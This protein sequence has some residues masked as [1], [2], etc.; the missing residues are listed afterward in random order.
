MY[1]YEM[2]EKLFLDIWE[3]YECPEEVSDP[4]TIYNILNDIIVKS[5]HW[6]VLDHY[7]HINF[8]EVKKVEYDETTGIFKLFWLD[9]NSFREKRLRHEIDEFEM[10]IWQ[11][12]GYC[13]YEYIALDIYNKDP[14]Y[15]IRNISL[16]IFPL[17]KNS[18]IMLFVDKYNR[19]YSKFFKQLQR[20]KNTEEELA[21][22][23]YILFSYCE[24][25]FIS[26]KV[27][28]DILEKLKRLMG[29]TSSMLSDMPTTIDEQLEAIKKVYNFSERN[30]VPNLLSK[31]YAITVEN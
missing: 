26:P 20:C 6:I 1:E 10:L 12:S 22:I 2:S 8:D 30:I 9:N 15:V 18:I 31:E 13:T 21:I 11:M 28:K 16:C 7:S 14:K 19:R 25:Y 17:E 3:K 23:N 27:E 5:K 29:K 24:D 4:L